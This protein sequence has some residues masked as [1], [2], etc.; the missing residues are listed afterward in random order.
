MATVA[1]VVALLSA[2]VSAWCILHAIN[3][4]YVSEN[5]PAAF[6]FAQAAHQWV[7]SLGLPL[8]RT[9]PLGVI[10]GGSSLVAFIQAIR[11]YNLGRRSR[12]TA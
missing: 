7:D 12:E 2:I 4:V 10:S 1:A 5:S 11:F 6:F 3:I 8:Q 9:I